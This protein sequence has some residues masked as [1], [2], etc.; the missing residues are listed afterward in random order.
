MG[1]RGELDRGCH[2]PLLKHIKRT[3][4][5]EEKRPLKTDPG[6]V[7]IKVGQVRIKDG[8]MLCLQKLCCV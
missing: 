8:K 4:L 3:M 6:Q 2:A 1:G 5:V 7:G